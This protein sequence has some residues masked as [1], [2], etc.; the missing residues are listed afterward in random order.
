ME[1]NSN[2][3]NGYRNNIP[4]ENF[5]LMEMLLQRYYTSD[6]RLKDNINFLEDSLSKILNEGISYTLQM[7]GRQAFSAQEL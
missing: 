6:I 4:T 7:E 3:G 2:S 1:Y 5:M